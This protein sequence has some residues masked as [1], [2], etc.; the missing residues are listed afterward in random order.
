MTI[1]SAQRREIERAS[2]ASIAR[3]MR[4]VMQPLEA[5]RQMAERSAAIITD[6]GAWLEKY[7]GAS[8]WFTWQQA[9][10]EAMAVAVQD[11]RSKAAI[12]VRQEDEPIAEPAKVI[13]RGSPKTG[14]PGR[15]NAAPM[16]RCGA[17]GTGEITDK[18]KSQSKN[19]TLHQK[20]QHQK[21][22]LYL[23]RQHVGFIA[24]RE[25]FGLNGRSLGAWR[26]LGDAVAAVIA[27][28]DKRR[29]A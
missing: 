7:G 28:L 26:T 21:S 11:M 19:R 2:Q 12:A 20:E 27:S 4:A 5:I 13:L 25:A 15:K 1:T 3:T 18:A 6:L 23:G 10:A 16:A 9:E 24:E 29:A 8:P 17:L 22:F 14:P